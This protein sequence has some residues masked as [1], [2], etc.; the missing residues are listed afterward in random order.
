MQNAPVQVAREQKRASRRGRRGR[1]L[2]CRSKRGHK[3]ASISGII[4]QCRSQGS[5]RGL[6][7]E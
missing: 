7:E 5:T 1:M 3:R 2:Q 6:V 4:L